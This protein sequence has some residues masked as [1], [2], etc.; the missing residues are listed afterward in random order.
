MLYLGRTIL[1]VHGGMRRDKDFLGDAAM[2][3][4][5]D[6]GCL[7]MVEWSLSLF[8]CVFMMVLYFNISSVTL[9]QGK[10]SP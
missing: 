5:V 4:K 9:Q 3:F 2:T 8:L 6:V 1:A 7:W 10:R